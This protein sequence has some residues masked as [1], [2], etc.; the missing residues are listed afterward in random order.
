[1]AIYALMLVHSLASAGTY[2]FAKRALVELNAYELGL[3]RFSLAAVCYLA[4]LLWKRPRI[5]RQDWLSF[6][7]LGFIA[8]PI[9]QGFFLVGLAHTTAGHSALLYALT[10]IFVFLLARLRLGERATLG[11]VVG[12]AFAFAGVVVVLFARNA[13][14]AGAARETLYGDL[15]VLVAVVA[16][17]LFSVLGKPFAEKYGPTVTTGLSLVI[18]SLL[19]LPV[20]VWE[21]HLQHFWS[22]SATGW[23]MVAYLVLVTS[24]AAYL[25]YYWA[26]ARV[27]AS[28]V[29]VFSNLQPVM[30]AAL[31][32][33]LYGEKLTTSFVAGGALVL[34]GVVMTERG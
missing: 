22:L 31:A 23:S 11:K 20:G 27:E 30:T 2:L 9:N 32:W 19:F 3:A 13:L 34:A 4:L 10:P 33:A 18:G 17:A 21:S 28:R 7:L 8:V 5:E 25:I 29:A 1:M 16:W 24:V 14:A 15:L 26:L 12:I 6:L